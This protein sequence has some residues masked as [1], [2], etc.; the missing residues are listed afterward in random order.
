MSAV[1]EDH[2]GDVLRKARRAANVDIA[3][4]ARAAGVSEA[5][6]SQV[7]SSGAGSQSL[8]L[9]GVAAVLGLSAAKLQQLADFRIA[10]QFDHVL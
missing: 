4:V 3:A 2:I 7:E 9:A 10:H 6:W 1:L 8:N 5:A